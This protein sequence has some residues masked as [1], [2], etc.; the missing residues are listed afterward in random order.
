MIITRSAK[1]QLFTFVTDTQRA[2][3]SMSDSHPAYAR[4]MKSRVEQCQQA[5]SIA[6]KRKR[7]ATIRPSGIGTLFLG[8]A[9]ILTIVSVLPCRRDCPASLAMD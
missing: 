5:N 8:D 9:A 3:P 1:Y 7:V 2:H 4:I 6:E